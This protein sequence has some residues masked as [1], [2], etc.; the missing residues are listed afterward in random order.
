MDASDVTFYSNRSACYAAIGRWEEAAEDGKQCI[1]TDKTFVK[2][3]F[4]HALALQNLS[5]LDGALESVKRGLGIESGNADLKRMS[6]EI[7][8]AQRQKRV[9]AAIAQADTQ[10]SQH[11]IPGAFRTI[12]QALRLDPTNET[13]NRQMN[14]VRPLFE[15]AEKHRVSSLDPKERV[16]EEGD[17]FFKAANF[18]KA[19]HSYTKCLDSIHDKVK[20]RVFG[21]SN[22]I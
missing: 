11:D 2:G 21:S 13:L 1:V 14:R 19:I 16:K 5:N 18:E 7:E 3:Y 9:E 10:I 15:R 4:R 8:E 12:D 22:C 20:K 6:R 17:N